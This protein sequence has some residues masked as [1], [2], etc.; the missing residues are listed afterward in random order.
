MHFHRPALF[1]ALLLAP[2]L[3]VAQASKPYQ[4]TLED[5]AR[6]ERFLGA[7]TNPLVAGVAGRPTWLADGRFWYRTANLG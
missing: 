7:G 4:F 1:A 5:Y 6:A 3:A 2:T